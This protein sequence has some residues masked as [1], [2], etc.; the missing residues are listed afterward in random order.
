[1]LFRKVPALLLDEPMTTFSKSSAPAGRRNGLRLAAALL[2]I[3]GAFLVARHQKPRLDA[4]APVVRTEMPKVKSSEE[5]L[6]EIPAVKDGS[7]SGDA[8][9]EAVARTRK[10]P[11]KA[12][13]WVTLGEV[14]AQRLR[15][16]TDQ[17]Y[18]DFAEGAYREALR[19]EPADAD[20]MSGMAWVTG[21]RHVFDQS[22]EWAHKALAIAPDSADSFAM[23][24]DAALELGDYDGALEAYQKMMDLRPDLSSWSRGAYLLWITGE[25]NQGMTLMAKAI[26]AGG[27]FAEN[28]AWCRAKLATMHLHAGAFAAAAQVLEPSLRGKSK[29]PHVLL[30]A[31]QLAV[32]TRNFE[33]AKQYYQLLMEKGPNHE[34]LAGLGDLCAVA[35][36]AAGAERYY[37]QVEELHAAHLASGVHD[38]LQ[39]AKFFADHDRNPVEAVRLAEQHKLS[40]NVME[41]DMLAWVYFKNGDQPRAIEAI[42]R[43]LSK[44]TPDGEIHYHAGMIA[45]KAGDLKSARK[46]LQLAMAM[47]PD[48]SL[49]QAPIAARELE[50][51]STGKTAAADAEG[52]A[53]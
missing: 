26:A 15:D 40:R 12:K 44:N 50:N 45:A 16:T 41:A 11:E 51:L 10:N 4:R 5:I 13:S 48:F 30:A 35:G 53:R 6:T 46:H 25:A 39:M 22:V 3:L 49:L 33:V 31:A 9:V 7:A 17:R 27:P 36:D 1:M 47:N 28:T 20:A 38:H 21:G 34:A 24:G 42:K 18:Y 14:L 52:G 2:A 23:L 43:A 29:N 8:V 19:I 32:A 37:L